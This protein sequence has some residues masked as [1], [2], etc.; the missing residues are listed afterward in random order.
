MTVEEFV[1]LNGFQMFMLYP[2]WKQLLIGGLVLAALCVVGYEI[3]VWFRSVR[4]R[5]NK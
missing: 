2:L 1:G 3:W 4:R 5:K